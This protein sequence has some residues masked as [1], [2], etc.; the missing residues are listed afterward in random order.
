VSAEFRWRPPRGGQVFGGRR[1]R[2]RTHPIVHGTGRPELS[3]ANA[4]DSADH[5]ELHGQVVLR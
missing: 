3:V 2:A 1:H 4:D 5:D